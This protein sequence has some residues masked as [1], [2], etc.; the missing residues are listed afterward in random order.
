MLRAITTESPMP[1][2]L[3]IFL[4]LLG[5]SG[6][7]FAAESPPTDSQAE[8][9]SC[10]GAEAQIGPVL[11]ATEDYARALAALGPSGGDL[12]VPPVLTGARRAALAN[13]FKDFKALRPDLDHLQGDLEVLTVVV[14]ACKAGQLTP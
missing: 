14:D 7:A 9:A 12:T 4:L 1:R 3:V 13:V 2:L 11:K 10:T 8:I 6:A 5:P